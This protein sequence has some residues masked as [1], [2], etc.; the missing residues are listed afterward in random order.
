MAQL[1]AHPNTNRKVVGLSP[2]ISTDGRVAKLVHAVALEAIS[3]RTEGSIPSLVTKC[4]SG[5]IGRH[6]VFKRQC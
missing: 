1:K 4:S 2:T 5:G 6:A 3:E